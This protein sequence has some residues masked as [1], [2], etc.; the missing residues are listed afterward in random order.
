MKKIA[1]FVFADT[2]THEGLG[3]VV[4]A[5]ETVKEFKIAGDDV[6][7]Y[8][9]GTGTKWPGELVKKDHIANPL[10]ELVR[11][12][13]EGACQFC[14]RAFSAEDSVRQCKVELVNEFE[15][16]ISVKRLVSDGYQI[17]NF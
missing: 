5:L 16:H 6:R 3:R 11:D 12:N 13:V 1:V 7:L 8:F 15:N 9:D 17:I 14:A 4:N 2:Q 10:Y